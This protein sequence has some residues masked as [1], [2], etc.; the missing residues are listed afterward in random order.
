MR[1]RGLGNGL[2]NMIGTALRQ[3]VVFVPLAYLLARFRG[4]DDVWFSIWAAEIAAVCYVV[5][6]S[7]MEFQ[8]KVEPLL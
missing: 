5:W 1:Y 4:I 6:S 2:V 7:R 3:F 8:K